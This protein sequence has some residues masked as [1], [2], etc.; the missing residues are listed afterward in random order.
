MRGV[1]SGAPPD[2][3]PQALPFS[4]GSYGAIEHSARHLHILHVLQQPNKKH[5]KAQLPA[6]P[7]LFHLSNA[8][9]TVT[10]VPE[11]LTRGA[12]AHLLPAPPQTSAQTMSLYVLGQF[13]INLCELHQQIHHHSDREATIQAEGGAANEKIRRRNGEN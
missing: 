8:D 3:H 9:K 12:A 6:V 4:R 13:T 2:P 7:T 1:A 11:R 5:F 10:E